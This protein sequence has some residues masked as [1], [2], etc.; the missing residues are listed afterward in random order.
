MFNESDIS[1][2]IARSEGS[3]DKIAREIR[4]AHLNIGDAHLYM[5]QS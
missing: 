1:K 3:S 5:K 2:S 4:D